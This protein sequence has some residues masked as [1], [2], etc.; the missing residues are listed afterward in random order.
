MNEQLI[1]GILKN[2]KE[3]FLDGVDETIQEK[4]LIAYKKYLM[5]T[6][7]ST[8]DEKDD[9]E[10]IIRIYTKMEIK[11]WQ[12]K[13]TTQKLAAIMPDEN[14]DKLKEISNIG[15]RKAQRK[16]GFMI[17]EQDYFPDIKEE[18]VNEYIKQMKELAEQ[19]RP[20]N[21]NIAQTYLSE[22]IADFQFAANLTND[23]SLRIGRMM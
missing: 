2:V 9:I 14:L 23:R 10:Q 20:Y 1:E 5:D 17:S 12:G 6:Y 15:Y 8:I 7:A 18:E 11:K 21:I 16:V 22:G 13:N 4:M 19:V 3:T